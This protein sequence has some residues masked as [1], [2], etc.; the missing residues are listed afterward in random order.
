MFSL[1]QSLYI[2]IYTLVLILNGTLGFLKT[3]RSSSGSDIR[4]YLNS[5]LTFDF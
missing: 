5:A 3:M 1:L 2:N 4:G